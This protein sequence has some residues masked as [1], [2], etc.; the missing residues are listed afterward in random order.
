PAAQREWKTDTG[1]ARFKVPHGLDEDDDVSPSQ[2][3]R[4]VIQLMT[5]RS[6]DQFNTTIY[7]YDDRFRGV[8][9]TRRVVFMNRNDVVRL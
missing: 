3:A 8:N 7:G 1:K 4:E 6:N 9:G 5:L 2:D